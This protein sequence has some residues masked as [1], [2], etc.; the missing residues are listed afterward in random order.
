MFNEFEC[1]YNMFQCISKEFNVFGGYSK[2]CRKNTNVYK[3]VSIYH[4]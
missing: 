3:C 2:V 1:I 4:M